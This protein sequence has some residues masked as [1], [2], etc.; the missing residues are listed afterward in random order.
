VAIVVEDYHKT[1]GETVAV[2]G[3][4]FRVAPGEILGLAGPNG[5]G[6]TTTLRALAGIIQPTRGRLSIAGHDLQTHPVEAKA[7][8][9]YV[10]DDPRLFDRLTV[11]EHFRFVAGA[12]RLTGWEERAEELL[13]RLELVEKRDALCSDLSRGMRQ[14]V[15]IGCGYLHEPQAVLLDEPLTG[16]DPRGIRT[17]KDMILERAAAGTA[18]IVSSHLLSLLEDLATTVMIVRKGRVML[19]SPMAELQNRLGANGQRETLEE[20]FFR[21]TEGPEAGMPNDEARMTKE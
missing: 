18:F 11:W 13:G 21:L 16:L 3:I 5:A 17:M 4:S 14:K 15:A 8:L 7:R 1:Y 10:P 6:K 12:Y 20:L 19:H 2:Q 9:A